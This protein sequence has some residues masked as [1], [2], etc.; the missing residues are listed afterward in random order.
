MNDSVPD[1]YRRLATR[2]TDLIDVVP[3]DRWDAASPCEGWSVAD[4]VEHVVTTE[5]DFFGRQPFGATAAN[6]DIADP[7]AAWPGVR[8][9]VQSA[10]DDPVTARHAFDGYFGPTTFAATLADFYCADLVVHVWDI[11]RAAGLDM[12]TAIDASE[13]VAIRAGFQQIEATMRQ[14][15]LFGA[16]LDVPSDATEQTRFLAFL[17]RAG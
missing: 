15:G 16:A 5:L 4:V 1:R 3:A 14:P 6:V 9:L 7:V 10:L 11:A 17:G 8:D 2:F 12:F 13:M